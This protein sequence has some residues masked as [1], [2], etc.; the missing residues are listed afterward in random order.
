MAASWQFGNVRP[1]FWVTADTAGNV[2]VPVV[3]PPEPGTT[4]STMSVAGAYLQV[5][6][7]G[8]VRDTLPRG[9][10]IPL[11]DGQT[12][13]IV[14]G[15]DHTK[16]NFTTER[17]TV[18]DPLGRVVAGR[19]DVY[20]IAVTAP[21]NILRIERVTNPPPIGDDEFEEWTARIEDLKARRAASAAA[22]PANAR[23]VLPPP[24]TL[25]DT[26]DKPFYRAIYP[27]DDGRL[28]IHRYA[29]AAKEPPHAPSE[30]GQPPPITWR[31]PNHFDVFEPDGTLLGTVVVPD[32]YLLFA[33]RGDTVW[34]VHYGDLDVPFVF[35]A[36]LVP[37]SSR[38]E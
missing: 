18:I 20:S 26:R 32:R 4:F 28:W 7:A 37:R 9:G 21:G 38:S 16:D 14:S 36:R 15:G 27:A 17:H 8:E 6:P 10:W 22:Y 25:P 33:W 35:R 3:L 29:R 1:A 24:P 5:G 19:T 11:V 13:M 2:Y 23:P 34:G 31:E 12:R 30:P